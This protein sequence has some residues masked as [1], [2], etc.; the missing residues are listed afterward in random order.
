M[1]RIKKKVS[2]ECSIE[3]YRAALKILGSNADLEGLQREPMLNAQQAT[4]SGV[5]QTIVK[6]SL[7][8]SDSRTQPFIMMRQFHSWTHLKTAQCGNVDTNNIPY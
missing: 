6:V 1:N 7:D 4:Q 5:H 2:T 3:F 8:Q